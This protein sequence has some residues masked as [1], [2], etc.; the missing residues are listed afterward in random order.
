MQSHLVFLNASQL[1]VCEK[2]QVLFLKMAWKSKPRNGRTK[3]EEK[4]TVMLERMM[5]E[6]SDG[7]ISK[8]FS[9]FLARIGFA[10]WQLLQKTRW[11][12]KT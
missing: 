3:M 10:S 12:Q 4:Q 2:D 6:W 7:L 9:L 5:N 8:V 11:T 1:N